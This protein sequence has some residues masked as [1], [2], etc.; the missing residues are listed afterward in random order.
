MAMSRPGSWRCR[1]VR[2]VYVWTVVPVPRST[3]AS[4]SRRPTCLVVSRLNGALA[5][6]GR[7]EGTPWVPLPVASL[8]GRSVAFEAMRADDLKL[9]VDW[10][11]NGGRGALRIGGLVASGVEMDNLLLNLGGTPE[12]HRLDVNASGPQVDVTLAAQGG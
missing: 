3:C 6:S 1:P 12:A 2:T 5:G 7:L 4:T 11:E 10:G 9:D 8:D